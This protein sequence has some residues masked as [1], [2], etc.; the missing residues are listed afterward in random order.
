M[1][2]WIGC[3]WMLVVAMISGELAY[4]ETPSGTMVRAKDIAIV[5]PAQG[6]QHLAAGPV[7]F[8][9][10]WWSDIHA[11]FAATS[12]GDA[13][14]VENSRD[15][16]R[17]VAIRFAPCQP[18]ISY[19]SE[20]N[21]ALCE[22]QLRLVWQ[23]V[24]QQY[25]GR[26]WVAYAD[27][28]AIHALYR[29]NGSRV[30]G[31]QKAAQW[32]QWA[33]QA[34]TLKQAETLQYEA[35]NH[36]IVAQVAAELMNL[37]GGL[38]GSAYDVVGE[39]PEFSLPD[40]G[41]SF[42]SKLGPFLLQYARP[43]LLTQLTAFSLPEGR[44][45]P[46][47]DEWVFVA[48]DPAAS[49]QRLKAQALTVR[50][51]RDGRILADYGYAARASVRRDEAALQDIMDQANDEVKAELKD[52]VIWTFAER[53]AKGPSIAA[54][55]QT[56]VAHTSC[57]SCHK[58]GGLTFDL[59]NLSYLGDREIS[60]SPRVEMDVARELRWLRASLPNISGVVADQFSIGRQGSR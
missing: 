30:L 46:M 11:S 8:P 9:V 20:L 21:Q 55:E 10:A 53:K 59:H 49:G 52:A 29:I 5:L 7:L 40:R 15:D 45:P 3:L 22:P 34:S 26:A 2:I 4:G 18:L 13:M 35:L 60:I 6:D 23:P 19:I 43:E 17:L 54:P 58:L 12:V 39:R 41:R 1:M 28:R 37:R 56:H 38:P 33:R 47:I 50:S 24:H 25:S 31:E 44:D 51:R 42:L 48:F 32:R 57:A 27:D 36:L 16:W 14:E